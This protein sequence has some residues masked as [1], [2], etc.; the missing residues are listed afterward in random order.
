MKKFFYSFHYAL[1]GLWHCCRIEQNFIIELI[2]TW[3][4]IMLAIVLKCT[5]M[6]WAMLIVCIVLVLS[7][8]M[9]NTAIER[10]CDHFGNGHNSAVKVIKDV[11]AGA[12][13]L[14]SVASAIIGCIV[15]IPKLILFF[16]HAL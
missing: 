4:V 13:L 1:Q 2:A 6:E 5:G 16:N 9:I 3:I 10:A 7:M 12:V 15:F 14:A 8:E 11:A